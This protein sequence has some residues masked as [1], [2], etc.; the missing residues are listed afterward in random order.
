MVELFCEN[1]NIV[2]NTFFPMMILHTKM[3]QFIQACYNSYGD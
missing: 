2:K 1:L 3:M